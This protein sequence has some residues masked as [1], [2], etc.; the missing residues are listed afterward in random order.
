MRNSNGLTSRP[1]PHFDICMSKLE[2]TILTPSGDVLVCRGRDSFHSA[3]DSLVPRRSPR[4]VP[5]ECQRSPHGPCSVE[6]F[7]DI[8]SNGT[9]PGNPG[10]S[11][12]QLQQHKSQSG[13][14]LDHNDSHKENYNDLS[15]PPSFD[16]SNYEAVL[17]E[18]QSTHRNPL[19]QVTEHNAQNDNQ[20]GLV[21]LFSSLLSVATATEPETPK[22]IMPEQHTVTPANLCPPSVL[23]GVP[24][25][26]M[27]DI[28]ISAISAHALGSHVLL[29]ST[30]AL[31]FSY[32]SNQ[33]GQLGLGT[34]EPFVATPTLVTAVL[35]GGG[36]TLYC[37]AG[38]DYSLI[39][40][41]TNQQRVL[42]DIEGALMKQRGAG[43]VASQVT[44]PSGVSSYYEHHQVY[45]F[46]SNKNR[47]LGLYKNISNPNLWLPHRVALHAKSTWQPDTAPESSHA[48]LP[49]GIFCLAASENH[50]AALVRSTK[51][52]VD[53]YMWGESG[54]LGLASESG[55][56]TKVESLS[57]NPSLVDDEDSYLNPSEYPTQVALGGNCTFVLLNTGR[58]LSFGGSH[59]LPEKV[60]L[61]PT[62][63][64]L[65][66]PILS[67]SVGAQHVVAT[68]ADEKVYT[69][70]VDPATQVTSPKPSEL[71]HR[72]LRTFA[73]YDTSAFVFQDGT[74]KTCG[75]KSGRLGQGEVPPNPKAPMPLFGGLRLWR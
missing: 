50:S 74:L 68:C 16:Y 14:P 7:C 3:E 38:V 22:A 40:V 19:A 23:H 51:G 8:C 59:L 33:Y 20:D 28:R 9:H 57:Y 29:I 18:K 72:A 47:K 6:A 63:I 32:G 48:E 71:A 64:Q 53:L 34:L 1:V 13:H 41:K 67:L 44:E 61:E 10:H 52:E 25:C 17:P 54:A 69:W 5:H 75:V 42:R 31:L 56:V 27:R 36:K 58:C 11:K 73:G 49:V 37:A 12:H 39:A 60:S 66:S 43:D 30:N 35:E 24:T 70:G 26:L 45:G 4:G 21:K 65:E 15:A 55:A 46:G 62:E 2:T